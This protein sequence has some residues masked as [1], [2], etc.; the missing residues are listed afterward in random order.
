MT[1][2]D[3]DALL[4]RTLRLLRETQQHLG[5]L[6]TAAAQQGDRLKSIG[7]HLGAHAEYLIREGESLG[8]QFSQQPQT[9]IWK[10]SDFPSADALHQLTSEIRETITRIGELSRQLRAMGFDPSLG[11]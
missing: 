4:G 6:R 7:H 9:Q 5:V 10:E 8:A 2:E 11:E 1:S 3:Q